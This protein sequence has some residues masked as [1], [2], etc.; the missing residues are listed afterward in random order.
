MS[1]YQ[2]Y[3]FLAID[4]PVTSQQ[5]AELRSISTRAEI[6]PTR[7]TNTYTYGDFRGNPVELVERYFDAHVYIANWG[8]HTLIFGIP[9]TAVD[10]QALRAYQA[11]DG[12]H[13]R[14]RRGRVVVTFQKA[15]EDG[16]DWVEDDEGPAWMTALH[17]LR[18]D[19]MNGDLRAA[20][21]GWLRGLQ[22]AVVVIDEERLDEDEEPEWEAGE[23]DTSMLE[24]P[25]PPGLRSLSGPLRELARFLELDQDL[26]AVAAAASEPLTRTAPSTPELTRWI[27]ALP[28]DERDAILLRVVQGDAQVSAELRRRFREATA[29]PITAAAT[30]RRTIGELFAASREHAERRKRQEAEA[31]AAERRRKAEAARQAR[32]AHLDAMVGNEGPLWHQVQVLIVTKKPA[33][34]DRAV[35]IVK[36]LRDLAQREGTTAAFEERLHALRDTF[37]T[38]PAFLRRLDAKHLG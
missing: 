27:G 13:V 9:G 1:E 31:A 19:L 16:G 33:D 10:A 18:A 34:Y 24:P 38:R 7:F 14:E 37:S 23:I 5:M 15:A 26:L 8:T 35:M 11:E 21:L 3:E 20:Y 17:G 2:Y 30:K 22:T 36:D 25:V 29:P 6:S 32:E 28:S 4:T 12:F